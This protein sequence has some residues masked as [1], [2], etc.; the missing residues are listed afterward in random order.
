MAAA[1]AVEPLTRIAESGDF[2]LA[3]SRHR[4]ARPTDDPRVAPA[5]LGLLANE[6]LRPAVVDTL[7]ALGDEECVAPLVEPAQRGDAERVRRVAAALDRIHERYER[8]YAAG[9]HIVDLLRRRITDDGT[10]H[11]AAAVRTR[12]APLAPLVVVLGWVRPAALETLVGLL[13]QPEVE[14]QTAAA[15]TAI[16]RAATMPL[17]DRLASD[18]RAARLAA[19]SI[20]GRLDDARAVPVLMELLRATDTDL[21][22]TAAGALASIGD[23]RALDG[24]LPLF[25]HEHAG[26][27]QAAIAAVST[28][29]DGTTAAR[30]R[31]RLTAP[32]PRVRECAIRIAGYFGFDECLTPI[33]ESLDDEDED[34]RRAAIEQLPIVEPHDPT[35]LEKALRD[36]TA[37]NRAAAAHA[38]RAMEHRSLDG[39]LMAALRD[40]DPWVRYFAADTL[41]HRHSEAAFDALAGAAASD[42]APH[43]R[44]AAARALGN[45]DADAALPLAERLLAESDED[46]ICAAI[47]TLARARS[48]RADELLE[49]A[50]RSTS[51]VRRECAVEALATRPTRA[52]VEALSWAARLSDPPH[53]AALAV[54]SLAEV[55]AAGER[56]V[57]NAAIAALLDLAADDARSADVVHALGRL[58]AGA[59]DLLA[60]FMADPRVPVRVAAA[61]ALA[62]MRHPRASS[63]LTA[64][65]RDVDPAVRNAGVAGFGRLGTPAAAPIIATLRDA[66]PDPGVRRRAGIVCERHGWT[67]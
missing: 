9:D 64:A 21:V 4:C 28:M 30:I 66:D 39:P 25:G 1:D 38:A 49:S 53:L 56:D 44:I 54:A 29:G 17:V 48:P 59:I 41:G 40:S 34:V 3:V 13:G 61:D 67:R 26:V 63:A 15:L 35:R 2:F 58:P 43:V 46:I 62:R 45:L 42:E 51:E 6:L 32:D 22:V 31:E 5:L 50:S 19:A 57:T 12:E 11:L 24:L 60:E 7:A 36:E 8:T 37:R 52:S 47:E 14:S 55:A 16:G 20:L 27:R 23:P 10:R 18:N 33:L 65:L